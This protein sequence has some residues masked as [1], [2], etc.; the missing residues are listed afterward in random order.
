MSKLPFVTDELS[1]GV[2]QQVRDLSGQGWV[3]GV[4]LVVALWG[5]VGVVRVL[6]D[7]VN[8]IWGVPRY[9]RLLRSC[10]AV[11]PSSACSA[12]GSSALRSWPVSPWPSTS[13][14]S[15]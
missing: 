4:S 11:S 13:P 14:S 3:L 12:S 7:T 6:Q 8:T 1:A 5:S 15:P 9:R 2:N 10:C